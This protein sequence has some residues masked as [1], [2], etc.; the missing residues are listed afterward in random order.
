MA[1]YI[2]IGQ[3]ERDRRKRLTHAEALA[4]AEARWRE[5]EELRALVATLG[6]RTDANAEA[7]RRLLRASEV[8]ADKAERRA[9]VKAKKE[10]SR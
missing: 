3:H 2:P 5:V 8:E 1:T 9:D 6:E 10:M 4:E 7:F